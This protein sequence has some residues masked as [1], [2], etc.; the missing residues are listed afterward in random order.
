MNDRRKH[1]RFELDAACIL[2]RDKTVGTI[3]DISMGGLS[4]M[5][6]DRGEC[7]QG[8]STQSNIYCKEHDMCAEDIRLKVIGTEMVQGE[9]MEKLGIRK[10]RVRFHQLE[11]SQKSQVTNIIQKSSL[12]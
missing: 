3:I 4:C 5:C 7:R 11:K 8:L 1:K 12:S 9:F 6:I 2:Y 10:C